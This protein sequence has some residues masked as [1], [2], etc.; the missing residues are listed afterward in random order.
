MRTAAQVDGGGGKGF[1]HGHQKI[2]GAQDATFVAERFRHRFAQGDADV[3]DGVVLVD[4]EVALCVD[5]QIE[6]AVA[7][8]E[9]E[10]VIEEADAGGNFGF[11]AAVKIQLQ[12]D[13][14]LFG[15]AMDVGASWFGG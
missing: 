6:S 3:F 12:M 1:V 14:G 15:V 13:V 10:H 4:V 9:V 5:R 8:D 7:S 2:A 11:S